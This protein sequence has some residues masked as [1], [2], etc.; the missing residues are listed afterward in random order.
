MFRA[1][2]RLLQRGIF[3][4]TQLTLR[5]FGPDGSREALP[6]PE[7]PR[8]QPRRR[9]PRRTPVRPGVAP[10]HLSVPPGVPAPA[11]RVRRVRSPEEQ[12]AVVVARLVDRHGEYNATR[13]GGALRPIPIDLSRRMRSR[14]GY[15][16]LASA[17]TPAIIMISRRHLRRHGWDEASQTLLHEMVHQ[18]QAEAG[19]PVDHGRQFRAKARAVGAVPRARRPVGGGRGGDSGPV[20]QDWGSNE[21]E[22]VEVTAPARRGR[23]AARGDGNRRSGA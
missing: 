21:T 23:N 6:D 5:L 12:D 7:Q 13:F 18:W 11:A 9:G 10:R 2:K 22:A 19:Q 1:L 3:D 15:Y 16:R 4:P 17:T 20:E 14:L 8:G